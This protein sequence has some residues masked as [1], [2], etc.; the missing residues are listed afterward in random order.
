[1]TL[2]ESDTARPKHIA[3][4]MPY[5]YFL[6]VISACS[7]E[8]LCVFTLPHSPFLDAEM[9]LYATDYLATCVLMNHSQ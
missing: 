5:L 2:N 6:P 4:L 7:G 9:S 1:M 8:G 3:R